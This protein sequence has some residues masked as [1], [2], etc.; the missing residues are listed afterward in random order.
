MARVVPGV[1]PKYRQLLNILRAQI[2]SGQLGP[3]QQLPTEEELGAQYAL[4][5]GTV[6]KAIEQLEAEHLIRTEQGVGSFVS[7][8]HASTIPF[9]FGSLDAD[10]QRPTERVTH[11]VL[12]QKVLPAPPDVAERLMISPGEPVIHVVR[13]RIVGG[14]VTGYA[15]RYLVEAMC[16]QLVDEDLRNQSVHRILITASMLPLL[17]TEFQIEAHL[18]AADE[19]A[20]LQAEPGT[21]AVVVNRMTFTAPNRPAVW[22]RALYRD[23]YT[24]DIRLDEL[25]AEASGTASAAEKQAEPGE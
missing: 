18:L 6:R 8:V 10:R 1:I 11:E 22:Y 12:E 24:I 13:R 21:P 14:R 17:R 15:E 20:L 19:A 23:G 7:S 2:L 16:P 5:R 25:E 9:H 3:D 4:S